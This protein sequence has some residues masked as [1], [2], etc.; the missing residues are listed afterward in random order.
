[1]GGNH[2]KVPDPIII[3]AGR[4]AGFA[5]AITQA[6][7]FGAPPGGHDDMTSLDYHHAAV[8][9]YRQIMPWAYLIRLADGFNEACH[10]MT[11]HHPPQGNETAWYT[12]ERYLCNATTAIRH[13]APHNELL[14]NLGSLDQIEPTTPPVM[15]YQHL[16]Q[17][18]TPQAPQQLAN[19][20]TT[21]AT[22]N[23]TGRR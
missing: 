14:A 1:M 10:Y 11:N 23:L 6:H 5:D 22:L 12:I 3:L 18:L 16:A 8:A 13:H 21:I 9:I 17:L 15:P 19:H 2:D 7:N 4:I 20:A